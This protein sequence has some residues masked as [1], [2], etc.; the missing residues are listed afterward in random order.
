MSPKRPRHRRVLVVVGRDV[1]DTASMAPRSQTK[2]V[3]DL[4]VFPKP[5]HDERGE[6][7]DGGYAMLKERG[8]EQPGDRPR[9]SSPFR[10][11]HSCTTRIG[12]APRTNVRS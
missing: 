7:R 2:L 10:S 12:I 6:F 4:L 11:T 9:P 3:K 1:S 5:I 8:R